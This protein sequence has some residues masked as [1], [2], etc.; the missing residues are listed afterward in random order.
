VSEPTPRLLPG[1][2]LFVESARVLFRDSSIRRRGFPSLVRRPS[3]LLL[4][5]FMS[6]AGPDPGSDTAVMRDRT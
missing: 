1:A 2:P 4:L 5:A 3:G 6:G